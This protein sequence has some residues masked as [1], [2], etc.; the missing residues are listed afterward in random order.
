MC[1]AMNGESALSVVCFLQAAAAIIIPGILF[2]AFRSASRVERRDEFVAALTKHINKHPL[3]RMHVGSLFA[4]HAPVRS[5]LSLCAA[6]VESLRRPSA[7][8]TCDLRTDAELRFWLGNCCLS[9]SPCSSCLRVQF[10]VSNTAVQGYMR[11]MNLGEVKAVAIFEASRPSKKADWTYT[12][13]RL[14]VDKGALDAFRA[15]QEAKAVAR[16]GADAVA[17]GKKT[18]EAQLAA[19]ATAAGF[20]ASDMKANTAAASTEAS[21]SSSATSST[22]ATVPATATG[23]ATGSASTDGQVASDA[24]QDGE[25]QVLVLTL[26]SGTK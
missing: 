17:A 7:H 2:L 14:E 3:V 26:S 11:M 22:S 23:G 25:G 8:R 1:T 18:A 9:V 24:A 15:E 5:S 21:S 19:A 6:E 16:Y 10:E 4:T 13:L 12:S 20:S